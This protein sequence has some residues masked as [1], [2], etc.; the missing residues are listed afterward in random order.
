MSERY[1]FIG[2]FLRVR[3]DTSG[4][5]AYEVVERPAAVGIVAVTTAGEVILVRQHRPAVGRET[6]EL[7]AG[8]IDPGETGVASA[9]RELLEETGYAAGSISPIT[10]LLA[11]PGYSDEH[12]ELVLASDCRL[13]GNSIGDKRISA[14]VQL[15]LTEIRS[16]LQPSTSS[17]VDGKTFAGL[18]WLLLHKRS[19]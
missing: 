19:A 16:L 12:I 11:S 18:A 6:L 10:T 4:D 7:P 8:I 14:V 2:R 15:S 13:V 5:S 3:L 1:P 17:L 9:H